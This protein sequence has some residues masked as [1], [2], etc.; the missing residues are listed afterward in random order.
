MDCILAKDTANT[1]YPAYD[2]WREIKEFEQIALCRTNIT[3]GM[4]IVTK[5]ICEELGVRLEGTTVK[6][7]LRAA[8]ML[9]LVR[10]YAEVV[11]NKGGGRDVTSHVCSNADRRVSTGGHNQADDGRLHLDTIATVLFGVSLSGVKGVPN[12][13]GFVTPIQIMVGKEDITEIRQETEHIRCHF[14]HAD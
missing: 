2:I 10:G 7:D 8:I 3:E 12:S 6:A 13:A 14:F 1:S 11:I 9:C 5:A 4:Y